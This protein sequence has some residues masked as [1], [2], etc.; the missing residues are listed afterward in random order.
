MQPALLT[1]YRGG[2]DVNAFL[3]Q[4]ERNVTNERLL[5]AYNK[6]DDAVN[7]AARCCAR[8]NNGGTIIK[9]LMRLWQVIKS[10]LLRR[11]FNECDLENEAALRNVFSVYKTTLESIA[12]RE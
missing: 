5:E 1:K 8:G 2:G 11:G 9:R 4:K 7:K 10:E 6:Y 3:R 12:P